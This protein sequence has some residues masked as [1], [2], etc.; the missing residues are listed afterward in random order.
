M[1]EKEKKLMKSMTFYENGNIASMVLQDS[2]SV[3]TRLGS[4][5]AEMIHFY[6]S[7]AVKR[8]CPVFGNISTFWAEEDEYNISPELQINLPF[9]V[10]KGEVINITYMKPENLKALHYGPKI[11]FL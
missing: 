5:P 9:D 11:R 1:M 7:G 2:L 3:N 10:F 8:I 4:F 6:E